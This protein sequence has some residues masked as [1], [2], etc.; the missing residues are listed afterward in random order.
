[1]GI[2]SLEDRR[3]GLCDQFFLNNKNNVKITELFPELVS[4]IFK[5]DLRSSGKYN[6]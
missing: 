5:Y 1:V 6:N 4:A 3:E 2:G